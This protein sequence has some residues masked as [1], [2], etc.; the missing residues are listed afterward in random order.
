MRKP[1]PKLWA[2]NSLMEGE[3]ILWRGKP[4]TKRLLTRDDIFM[5]PFSI[6]WGGFSI[7]VTVL[8]LVNGQLSNLPPIFFIFP[9]I[10]VYLLFGRFLHRWW[11]LKN[12]E[13]VITNRRLFIIRHSHAVT[14][15]ANNL[16]PMK[17]IQRRNGGGTIQF[18]IDTGRAW[19]S[20]SSP[21]GEYALENLADVQLVR[22]TIM[23]MSSVS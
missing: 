23:Q 14:I 7:G 18:V 15:S 6:M 11:R 1:N 9:I 19:N 8:L 12:T 2:E 3:E 22:R 20:L 17:I 5:L 4:G 21:Y 13:Y 10:G 16:P